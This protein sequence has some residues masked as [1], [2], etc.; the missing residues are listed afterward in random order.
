MISNHIIANKAGVLLLRHHAA[1]IQVRVVKSLYMKRNSIIRV[2]IPIIKCCYFY[3]QVS[4]MF[5][6]IYNIKVIESDKNVI[7]ARISWVQRYQN[8]NCE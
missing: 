5:E 1:C 4:K 2:N 6:E 8:D 3:S 7:K